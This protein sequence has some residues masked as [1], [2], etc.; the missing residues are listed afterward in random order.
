[1]PY[2]KYI[3]YFICSLTFECSAQFSQVGQGKPSFEGVATT[4]V[5]EKTHLPQFH[6]CWAMFNFSA[7]DRFNLIQGLNKQYS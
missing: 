6:F 1:M 7:F 5:V 3:L 2:I 4:P